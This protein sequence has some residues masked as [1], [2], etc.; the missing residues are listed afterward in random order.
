MRNFLFS[1]TFLTVLNA[2]FVNSET[3]WEYQQSTFQGFYM[4]QSTQV[5]GVEAEALDVI[6]AFKDGVCVGWVYVDPSG[7]T[8]IPLMGNDGSPAFGGYMSGGDT[9][10]LLIYDATYGSILPLDLSGTSVDLDGDFQ[11]DLFGEAPGWSN[12]EIFILNGTSSANNTFGCTESDACNYDSDATA[13]DGSCWSANDGCLCS[14]GEG[15]EVDC[16]GVCN[17]DS[18]LDDCDV[19][20]G[21]NADQDCA[22]VCFGDSSIDGCGVCDNDS[23]N[24]DLTCT[25]C[26][27]ECADNYDAGNLFDD[28]SCSYTIPDVEN[29]INTPG[30]CRVTLSWDAPEV[31]GPTLSYEVYDSNNNFIKETSQTTTQ[32][33]DLEADTQYCFFV[34][35]VNENGVSSASSIACSATGSDCGGFVGMQLTTS[36]NGWGFI[37]E[38]DSYNYIGFSGSATNGFDET[39]DIVEPPTSPDNWISLFFPHPEWGSSL[40]SNFTQDIRPEDYDFLSQNLQIWEGEIISNM[41]G[42][43]ALQL[44]YLE[45]LSKK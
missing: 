7:F 13:D 19:C 37:Q 23:S 3:G 25:G 38:T 21:G 8:T 1:I 43:A 12:N 26:T 24:D 15:S 11:D 35:A 10:D 39:L 4:L 34:V 44:D 14:D 2:G 30:E 45:G 42:N 32:I 36:I 17:G 33:L 40:G 5:D 9:A 31:C 29:F 41:S 20:N 18:E 22:G 27:D 28:G 16:A 6:G